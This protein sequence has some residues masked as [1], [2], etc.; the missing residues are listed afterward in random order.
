MHKVGRNLW[1]GLDP[2]QQDNLL[3]GLCVKVGK[4]ASAYYFRT[5]LAKLTFVQVCE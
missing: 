1:H 2:F 3:S 4:K 5:P